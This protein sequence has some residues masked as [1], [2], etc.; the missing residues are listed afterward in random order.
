MNRSLFPIIPGLTATPPHV[1]TANAALIRTSV[2]L[3]SAGTRCWTTL[4]SPALPSTA[5]RSR[6]L[7]TSPACSANTEDSTAHF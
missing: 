1:A 6:P 2:A 4:L 5:R 3:T 7:V